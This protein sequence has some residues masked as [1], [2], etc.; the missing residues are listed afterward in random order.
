MWRAEQYR[1]VKQAHLDAFCLRPGYIPLAIGLRSLYSINLWDYY[2]DH[3][4]MLAHELEKAG[5]V[6]AIGS[7]AIPC[8]A[9]RFDPVVLPSM[10]GA[11]VV[12]VGGRPMIAPFLA[13]PGEIERLR[14]PDV[15][16]GIVPVVIGALRYFLGN[17]P[18]DIVVLT[19]PELDPFDAALL[20]CG[21]E[22]FTLMNDEPALVARLLE[23][24]TE[25]F[26]RVQL[27]F[28]RLLDEPEREK[29][30][31]LGIAMPGIRVAADAL[32]NLSPAAIARFCYPV[33]DQLARAFGGVLVHYCPS[34][35]QRYYHVMKPVL[36][37]PHVLGVCTSG[38]VDYFEDGKNPLRLFEGKTLVGECDLRLG[39]GGAAASA[40]PNVNRFRSRQAEEISEWLQSDFMRLSFRGRR[41]LILRTAVST[42]EEG[43]QLYGLWVSAAT[44]GR[45]TVQ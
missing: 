9:P 19:P 45:E 18:D 40:S 27:L 37:C 43:R 4:A 15:E 44:G 16:S 35:S 11:R 17:T 22:L 42:V 20:M 34:P 2:L 14:A 7:D 32:V 29:V 28:K 1:T 41:G 13:G 31:Y 3:R 25:A 10:F 23:L 12:N 5:A 33:F 21:S 36:E 30:S 6:K 38:G 8:V 26:I 39:R 24:I